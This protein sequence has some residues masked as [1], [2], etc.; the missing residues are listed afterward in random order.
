MKTWSHVATVIGLVF[1]GVGAASGQPP[2][3][4]LARSVEELRHVV[5]RWSVTTELLGGDK[6]T[7]TTVRGTYELEWV[8]ADKVVRGR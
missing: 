1:L 7:A 2:P 6:T 8:V 4:R 5:G 3:E